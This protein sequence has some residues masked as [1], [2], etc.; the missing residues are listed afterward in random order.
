MIP[1]TH[2]F[3]HYQSLGGVQS[4]LRRHLELDEK[5]GLDSNFTA[6]FDGETNP[7]PRV[8]GLGLSWR[9]TV[10]SS[11]RR[12]GALLDGHGKKFA[13]Y[14]NFWGVP[15]FAD[16]DKAERRIGVLH[17]YPQ[18]LGDCLSAMNGL[19]D[20]VL[21]VSQPLKKIVHQFLP[22]L[23]PSRIAILPLPISRCPLTVKRLPV[24]NRQVVIGFN[25]R[26]VKEQKRVDRLPEL[27]RA[28]DH[29]GLNYRLELLGDGPD[30]QWLERRFAENS[31]VIIHG[32]KSGDEYWRILASWDAIIFTSDFEG[33]PL[34]LLEALSAGV[35]PIYPRINSGGDAYVSQLNPEFLYDSDDFKEVAKIVRSL[36]SI[37]EG[38]IERWR[39][40]AGELVEPHVG[41]GYEKTFSSFV[42]QIAGAPRV[43]AERFPPRRFH[44]TD[45]CPFALLVRSNLRGFYRRNDE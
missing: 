19:V 27:I 18:V 29:A 7:N 35:L 20:G 43:S 34:S 38:K 8:R 16:L 37:E 22:N 28:F 36:D 44:F 33:L 42:G 10:F 1:V 26:L 17:V 13:V 23:E 45:F 14:N 24:Q 30:Q 21:C 39:L 41:N 9:S 3:T 6:F 2:Y 40:R 11:R 4:L 25:G 32:R 12:F 5:W 31:R 15:F